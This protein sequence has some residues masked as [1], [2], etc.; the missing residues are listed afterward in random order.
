[1]RK[2]LPVIFSGAMAVSFSTLA[3]A[4]STTTTQPEKDSKDNVHYNIHQ[5]GDQSSSQIGTGNQSSQVSGSDNQVSQQAGS[6]HQ[7]S[8]DSTWTQKNA[9]NRQSGE[10]RQHAN[11]GWHKGWDNPASSGSSRY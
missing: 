9:Q 7:S 6:G 2:V 1:M 5:R 4:Q 3:F 11:K 10:N 8:Q